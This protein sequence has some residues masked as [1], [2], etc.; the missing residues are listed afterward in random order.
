M[1]ARIVLFAVLALAAYPA[2][3]QERAR[4][5]V[6]GLTVSGTGEVRAAPDEATVR[7]GVVRQAATADEAQQQA[8]RTAQAIL[9]ALTQAGVNREQ[10]QT[11]GLTLQPVYAPQ[12]PGAQ[13]EP[14]IVAYRASNE[15]TVR[16]DRLSMVGQVIDAG[17]KAGANQLDSL[18]FGLRDELPVR[19][20]ALAQAVQQ[21][22]EKART[23]AEALEVRLV[24]VLEVQEGGL[25]VR[26]FYEQRAV[27]AAGEAGTPVSP[28]QVN[29]TA[30]VTVRYQ[31]QER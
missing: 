23:I 19:Q 4:P 14:R 13:E 21:A 22:R 5:E 8:N 26:P 7:L 10:V 18:Q 12:R 3:G 20:R 6:P 30:T 17:L 16:V 11:S 24:K 28:G 1:S 27:M 29:I 9:A 15:V 31:I 25:V 2:L